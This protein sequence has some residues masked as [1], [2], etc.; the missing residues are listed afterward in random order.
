MKVTDNGLHCR[1]V[2]RDSWAAPLRGTPDHL[3]HRLPGRNGSLPSILSSSGRRQSYGQLSWFPLWVRPSEEP[4]PTF[5]TRFRPARQSAI[6][7]GLFWS[8]ISP[9]AVLVPTLAAALRRTPDHLYH[10]VPGPHISL[11]SILGSSRRRHSCDQLS[12][13]HSGSFVSS[14]TCVTGRC[15][16]RTL[17]TRGNS[18]AVRSPCCNPG[19]SS[20]SQR[21]P[22]TGTPAAVDFGSFELT[23]EEMDRR[24]LRMV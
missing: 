19:T 13:S 5:T 23:T 14:E 9:A 7:P 2:S 18:T 15:R 4:P 10:E 1:L 24:I 20:P 22:P 11:P 21:S 17:S 3:Y 12:G 16:S 6:D 8:I